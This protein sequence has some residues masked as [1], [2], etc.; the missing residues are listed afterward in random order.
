MLQ[1]GWL[2]PDPFNASQMGSLGGHSW[3]QVLLISALPITYISLLDPGICLIVCS[4]LILGHQRQHQAGPLSTIVSATLPLLL[5]LPTAN[6]SAEVSAMALYLALFRTLDWSYTTSQI[7]LPAGHIALGLVAAASMALKSTGIPYVAFLLSSAYLTSLRISPNKRI[8]FSGVFIALITAGILLLPWMVTM[9][10]SSGTLLYPF[11]G[12]G[13]R[14]TIYGTF[15]NWSDFTRPGDLLA[16]PWLLAAVVLVAMYMR[17]FHP[18]SP[19]RAPALYLAMATLAGTLAVLWAT[20]GT[21][22]YTFPFTIAAALVLIADIARQL[23]CRHEHR[24]GQALVKTPIAWIFLL[25]AILFMSYFPIMSGVNALITRVLGV[26]ALLARIS[27]SAYSP[28]KIFHERTIEVRRAQE[29]IPR[30]EAFIVKTAEPFLFNFS[31]NRVYVVDWAH[32]SSPPPGMPYGKNAE[33][34]ADYL[35]SNSVKYIIYE[36]RKGDTEFWYPGGDPRCRHPQSALTVLSRNGT[37]SGQ[38][39]FECA[40]DIA[41]ADFIRSAELLMATREHI[42]DDGKLA[43]L[44]L[45]KP[46]KQDSRAARHLTEPEQD[47]KK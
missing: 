9:H 4:A 43:V 42:F 36:H 17:G 25:A 38:A 41:M 6:A 37:E 8:P 5:I 3:L 47:A 20:A 29:S 1:A 46:R 34:L 28:P 45:S 24:I 31:R 35:Q 12:A 27:T 18:M 11:L 30:D 33:A 16:D 13:Y 22:R 10:L 14:G 2:V 39:A 40:M 32:G 23:E 7:R 15:P 44:D 26:P 19:V 21:S